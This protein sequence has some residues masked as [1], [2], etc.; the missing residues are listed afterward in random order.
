MISAWPVMNAAISRATG[1]PGTAPR[2][3]VQALRN[4]WRGQRSELEALAFVERGLDGQ[5]VQPE[6]GVDHREVSGGRHAQVQPYTRNLKLAIFF[7][8]K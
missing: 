8:K 5:P 4:R 6:L 2:L 1:S 3:T 7:Q